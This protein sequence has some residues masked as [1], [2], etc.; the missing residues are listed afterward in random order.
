MRF[1]PVYFRNGIFLQPAFWP[2]VVL[3]LGLMLSHAP[4]LSASLAVE[5]IVIDTQTKRRILHVEIA[6]TPADRARG[7][8]GRKRLL[9]STGMLFDFHKPLMVAFWMKNT[10]LSLDML[11]VRT[12]GTISTVATNA[13]PFSEHEITSVEPIRAVIEIGGGQANALGI[14]PGNVVHAQTFGTALAQRN[15]PTSLQQ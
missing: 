15:R 7:L 12:D 8:M 3:A 10:P 9:P 6:S 11:F 13:V 2:F 5:T 1:I 14:A 4:S